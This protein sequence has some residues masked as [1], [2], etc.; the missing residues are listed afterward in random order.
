MR[1]V[2]DFLRDIEKR[3]ALYVGYDD[4]SPGE[5]LRDLEP[6][7]LGY[8][9][10]LAQHEIDEPGRDFLRD[11]ADYLRERYGWSSSLGPIHAIRA[12]AGC[13]AD[14]WPLFWRLLWEL[15]DARFARSEHD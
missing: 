11:L 3:P 14:A 5:R 12:A 7:S 4:E 8:G 13:D 2:F 9:Y 6:I 15:R 10:A 1:T